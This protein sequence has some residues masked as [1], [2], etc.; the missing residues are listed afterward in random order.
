MSLQWNRHLTCWTT[1]QGM[2]QTRPLELVRTVRNILRKE[3]HLLRQV[4]QSSFL[5]KIR[6]AYIRCQ[7]RDIS[8]ADIF[9]FSACSD[10][11]TN[12]CTAC[13]WYPTALQ[14]SQQQ[15][16][17]QPGDEGIGDSELPSANPPTSGRAELGE[18]RGRSHAG[19][20]MRF[21]AVHDF[22]R[23]HIFIRTSQTG[24]SSRLS[25]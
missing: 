15:W 14:T 13:K 8:S 2:F 12:A 18:A 24:L 17:R 6:C 3:R 4:G 23:I 21:A 19:Y 20:V 11:S 9:L 1:F 25:A 16:R 22:V 10:F 7:T 5:V